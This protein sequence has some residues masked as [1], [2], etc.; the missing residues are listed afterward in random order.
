MTAG[1][2]VIAV[3]VPE[4]EAYVRGR[5]A[6]YDASFVSADPG[7]VHAHITLLGPWLPSPTAADLEAVAECL[8]EPF[9]VELAEVASFPSGLT[10]LRP[11]PDGP[12][13]AITD[14]LVKAFP[15]WPPYGG[16]FAPVPHL[17]LDWIRAGGPSMERIRDDVAGLLPARTRVDRVDLQWWANDDCRLLHSWRLGALDDRGAA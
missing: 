6:H 15:Q 14:R 12:L 10:Y 3:P 7:F 13:R 8:G 4:L 1:H 5:T 2:N 17:T 11:Q 16:E 9:D